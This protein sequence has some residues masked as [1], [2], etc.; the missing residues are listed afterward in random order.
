M[1]EELAVG[2]LSSR[3][4]AVVREEHV[5][6]TWR[7]RV[8][9]SGNEIFAGAALAGDE[10]GEVVALH[11][12]D[13]LGHALHD[14]AG[15]DKARQQGLQRPLGA[16]RRRFDLAISRLAEIESLPQHRTQRAKAL[17]RRSRECALR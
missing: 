15:V 8:N 14:G 13:L 16:P 6:A 5:V 7:S 11:P 17:E 9:C 1:A 2:K 3:A 4:G 10:N 12:L